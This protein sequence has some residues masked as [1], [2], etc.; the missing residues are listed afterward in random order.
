MR[1]PVDRETG[2][3]VSSCGNEGRA[4]ISERPH[5]EKGP[6]PCG[7]GPNPPLEEVEE[8]TGEGCRGQPHKEQSNESLV[9]V[10]YPCQVRRGGQSA[11]SARR[12]RKRT[13]NA[14]STG[15]RAPAWVSSP[16]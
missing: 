12:G 3:A 15:C 10:Q 16:R 13:W 11:Q 5:Q 8:T 7:P 6:E 2:T 14:P 9:A 4:I 1:A